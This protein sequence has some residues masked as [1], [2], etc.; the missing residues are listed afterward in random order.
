ML[1]NTVKP[2]VFL[3]YNTGAP[4]HCQTWSIFTLQQGHWGI[5]KQSIQEWSHNQ[6]LQ[7][8][9]LPPSNMEY[10]TVESPSGIAWYY[11]QQTIQTK[12]LKKT[13][14]RL[15]LLTGQHKTCAMFQGKPLFQA[16]DNNAV[17]P[18]TKKFLFNKGV[19]AGDSLA[20]SNIKDSIT[21]A[22]HPHSINPFTAPACKISR[23]KD[24]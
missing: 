10:S 20:L 12:K 11:Y 6:A 13:K 21:G 18:D 8:S 3:L 23:L 22:R 16:R 19:T 1:Q 24:A 15:K 2:E 7:L 4:K 17:L 14:K 9:M 5:I